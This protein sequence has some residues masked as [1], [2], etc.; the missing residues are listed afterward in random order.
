MDGKD[1][2]FGR[3]LSYKGVMVG[4]VPN[5]ISVFGYINASWT[6]K[7]DLVCRYLCRLLAR[8]D[9]TGAVS[10]TPRLRGG[11]APAAPFVEHFSAGYMQRSI[12]Q[13]PKQGA[14][15]PWRANQSY[16]ADLKALRFGPIE[17]GV[18]ELSKPAAP[19]ARP[20]AV[21]AA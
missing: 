2:D 21:A 12:D 1:V 4:D 3:T 7:A 10:A 8:M 13:W 6:L 14:A 11:V 20:G 15:A 19:A 17:D 18:L 5:L 16:F 9:E